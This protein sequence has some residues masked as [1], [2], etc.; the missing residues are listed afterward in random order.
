M[1]ELLR[2]G[3]IEGATR[4]EISLPQRVPGGQQKTAGRTGRISLFQSF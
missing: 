3:R 4:R 2:G 1:N